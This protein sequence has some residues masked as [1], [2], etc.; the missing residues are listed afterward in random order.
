MRKLKDALKRIAV[1]GAT[2]ALTLGM[3]APAT[4]ALAADLAGEVD[5]S[6][7][8]E[9]NQKMATELDKNLETKVTLSFPG[10]REAEPSDVVFVLDKS[11]FSDDKAIYDQAKSFLDEVKAKAEADGLDIKVGVVIFNRIGNVQ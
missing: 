6:T 11:A 1:I 3:A 2:M 7:A 4:T 8:L 9:Q 5:P 10:K